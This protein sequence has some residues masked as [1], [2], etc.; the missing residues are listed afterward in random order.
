MIYI[1]L[2][3]KKLLTRSMVYA[4][5]TPRSEL[6]KKE[7]AP[8]LSLANVY[9]MLF[10]KIYIHMCAMAFQYV[11]DVWCTRCK[12]HPNNDSKEAHCKEIETSK[13]HF[14]ETVSAFRH[15]VPKRCEFGW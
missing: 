13:P 1:F 4:G 6:S 3:C 7:Y 10:N 15:I 2:I 5:K 9:V 12:E 11:R 8:L 14:N